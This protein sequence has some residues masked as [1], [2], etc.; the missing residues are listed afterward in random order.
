MDGELDNFLALVDPELKAAALQMRHITLQFTPMTL[1]KLAKRRSLLASMVAPLLPDVPA[2]ELRIPGYGNAP[3]VGLWIVN[4]GAVHAP[5]PAVLHMH[6]GGFTAGSARSSVPHLQ[7]L[8]KE[9][10]CIIVSVDFRNA[11]EAR[12]DASLED[13]YA[14]LKWLHRNAGVL[15]VDGTRI[16]ILGESGGGGHAALL[17]IAARDRGEITLKFQALIYPMLD[18]RTGSSRAT[19]LHLGAFNWNTDANRFGWQCFLGEEPGTDSVP[20]RAVPS[21]VQSVAG[22]P[23]T[24]IGVGAL[25]LFA[26]ENLNYAS[27]LIDAGI[28][29]ELL[30]VPGC[31]HGFDMLAKDTGAARRFNAAK[32]DALRRALDSVP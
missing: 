25:D 5:R 21:R 12:Y 9:L 17:A 3:H 24:F 31:F 29:T 22:L 7:S 13:N 19:A 6:G 10:D 20:S 11:P 1:S 16:A 30:V 4:E 23:P 26:H 27:R 28:A 18:D 14:A 8:A 15:G 32:I 2:R